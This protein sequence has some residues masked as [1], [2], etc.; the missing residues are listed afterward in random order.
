LFGRSKKAAVE[1]IQAG[2]TIQS[3]GNLGRLIGSKVREEVGYKG[4]RC[5][6]ISIPD[7]LRREA[8]D[9]AIAPQ[10]LDRICLR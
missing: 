4:Q 6:N 3:T 2:R 7:R 1:H 8:N 5:V 10:T 9:R